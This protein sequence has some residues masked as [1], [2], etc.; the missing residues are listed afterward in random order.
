LKRQVKNTIR[1]NS[2][3]ILI[4]YQNYLNRRS[5][6]KKTEL[7]TDGKAVMDWQIDKNGQGFSPAVVSS[8]FIDPVLEKDLVDT[9]R[10][11]S[12]PPPPFG[13]NKKTRPR[14]H[15]FGVSPEGGKT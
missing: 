10:K 4:C 5:A 8:D 11:W 2:G 14:G 13:M 9:I 12:F 1:K 6:K 7:P 15:G 3:Q